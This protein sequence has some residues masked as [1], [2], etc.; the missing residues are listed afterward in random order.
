MGIDE[1]II[2]SGSVGIMVEGSQENAGAV[3]PQPRK[4]ELRVALSSGKGM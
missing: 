3:R 1:L 2:K 4:T